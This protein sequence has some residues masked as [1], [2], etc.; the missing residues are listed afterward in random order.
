MGVGW[1]RESFYKEWDGRGFIFL[2]WPRIGIGKEFFCGS[3]MGQDW[4][5]TPV[6]SSS[7][8]NK[9]QHNHLLDYHWNIFDLLAAPE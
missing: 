5:S 8:E 4:E 3:G 9:I 7:L 2:I 6:S 1:E